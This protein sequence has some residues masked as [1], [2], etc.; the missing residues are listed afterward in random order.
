MA[1]NYEIPFARA[2]NQLHVA[3][4][5]SSGGKVGKKRSIFLPQLADSLLNTNISSR[6]SERSFKQIS[7][8]AKFTFSTIFEAATTHLL[9]LGHRRKYLCNFNTVKEKTYK[10]S[11][12]CVPCQSNSKTIEARDDPQS[13]SS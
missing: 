2:Q 7:F 11:L 13:H 4:I 10:P 12:L 6:I 1:M 3:K 5:S 9:G 8:H